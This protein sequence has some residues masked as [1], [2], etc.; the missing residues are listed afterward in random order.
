[1]PDEFWL[2]HFP[3]GQQLTLPF[4][5]ERPENHFYCEGCSTWKPNKERTKDHIIP[6]WFLKR[7]ALF[8]FKVLHEKHNETQPLCETCNFRKGGWIKYDH[9]V[10]NDY[11]RRFAEGILAEVERHKKLY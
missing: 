10:V 7:A 1:M 2:E 6:D 3:E 11:M 8:G 4:P 5:P 9:P